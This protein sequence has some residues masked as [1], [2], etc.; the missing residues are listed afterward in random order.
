MNTRFKKG[1]TITSLYS[2][3]RNEYKIIDIKLIKLDPIL[4]FGYLKYIGQSFYSVRLSHYSIIKRSS[5]HHHPLIK[6]FQ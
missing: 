4:S 2:N 1:D 3:V 5:N 6:I